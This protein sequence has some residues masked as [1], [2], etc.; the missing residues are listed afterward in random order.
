VGEVSG[1]W[2]QDRPPASKPGLLIY[3]MVADAAAAVD[4][5]IAAGGQV[6]RPIDPDARAVFATFRDP[7]GNVLG[8]Y[9]QPGLAAAGAG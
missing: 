3:I 9:E 5:I 6:V 1:T 2:V 7:G 8:I 4:G